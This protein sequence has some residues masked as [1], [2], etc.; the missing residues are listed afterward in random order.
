MAKFTIYGKP[1]CPFCDQAKRLAESEGFEFEYKD[2]MADKE[3]REALVAR[4]P[5]TRTVPQIFYGDKHV[6]GYTEFAGSNKTGALKLMMET[7]DGA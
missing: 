7:Y 6:G 1:N 5:G 4:L 3:A 2:V